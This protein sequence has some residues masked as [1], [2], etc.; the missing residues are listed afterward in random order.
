MGQ[1]VY[2]HTHPMC[3][4]VCRDESLFSAKLYFYSRIIEEERYLTYLYA[5][6]NFASRSDYVYVLILC[7][8]QFSVAAWLSHRDEFWVFQCRHM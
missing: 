3:M 4:H 5:T 8:A 7:F 1:K 6:F 2:G